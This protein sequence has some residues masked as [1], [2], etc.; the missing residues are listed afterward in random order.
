MDNAR[1]HMRTDGTLE[2]VVFP[3][4]ETFSFEE[5]H[6]VT[7]ACGYYREGGWLHLKITQLDDRRE[8]GVY[9]DK[10]GNSYS[11]DPSPSFFNDLVGPESYATNYLSV[12]P[13]HMG[14]GQHSIGVHI[15]L[16]SVSTAQTCQPFTEPDLTSKTF[17]LT[18]CQFCIRIYLHS[19]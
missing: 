17:S 7:S 9:T 16:D 18:F 14:T 10:K 12:W 19:G 3:A 11:F 15:D 13:F 5:L 4:D 8:G 6:E 1:H 2:Q